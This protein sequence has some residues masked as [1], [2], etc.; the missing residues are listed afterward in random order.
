[1]FGFYAQHIPKIP[2]CIYTY[3]TCSR[4]LWDK[5]VKEEDFLGFVSLIFSKAICIIF[6]LSGSLMQAYFARK[7]LLFIL[8]RICYIVNLVDFSYFTEKN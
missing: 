3:V 1:M 6:Y 4:K 8:K 5:C 2:G 7:V